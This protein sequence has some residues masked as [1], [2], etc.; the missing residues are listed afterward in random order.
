MYKNCEKCFQCCKTSWRNQP[1][2]MLVVLTIEDIVRIGKETGLP[3]T[4]FAEQTPQFK[5]A[6]I[7]LYKMKSNDFGYCIFLKT[8]PNE[9]NCTIHE[10]KPLA[11]KSYPAKL[12]NKFPDETRQG[13]MRELT[14]KTSCN[15]EYDLMILNTPDVN[16]EERTECAENYAE[17]IHRIARAAG[18]HPEGMRKLK[19]LNNPRYLA[20]K[21]V[22]KISGILNPTSPYP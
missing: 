21:Y 10:I 22:Q 16:L 2:E 6:G 5:Q 15:D 3:Q 17:L 9:N 7:P 11:C 13:I 18:A 19:E 14:M 1:E 8:P 20:L 4:H 12:R